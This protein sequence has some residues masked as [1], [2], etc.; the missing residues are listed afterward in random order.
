MTALHGLVNEPATDLEPQFKAFSKGVDQLDATAKKVRDAAAGM[1]EKGKA[2]FADWDA[3]IAG[4]QNEDIRAGSAERKEA[5]EANFKD[6]QAEYGKSRDSFKPL[7][8]NLMDIRTALKADLTMNGLAAIKKSVKT[9]NGQA[10]DVKESLVKL[11]KS[12]REM[13]VKMSNAGP[14]PTPEKKK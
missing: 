9:V 2:Y 5:V 14:Q 8:T 13:G 1:D 10:E 12:F 7:M 6:I 11:E 4:I 3:Q